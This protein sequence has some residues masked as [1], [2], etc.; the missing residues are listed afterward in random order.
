MKWCRIKHYY[1]MMIVILMISTVPVIITG[2]LSYWQSSQAIQNYSNQEKMQ[3]IYQIQTNVEQVLKNIDHSITYF[4]RTSQL[5]QYIHESISAETFSDYDTI[6]RDLNHLQTLDTGIEDIVLVSLEQGWLINNNG[7]MHIDQSTKESITNHYLSLADNSTWI[8]EEYETIGLPHTVQ[9]RSSHYI[10]LAKKLPLLASEKTGLITVFIPSSA[11]TEIMERRVDAESF[12]ILDEAN[13]I[14]SHSNSNYIGDNFTMPEQIITSIRSQ[15]KEGQFDHIIDDIPYKV[16]YLHSDYNNWTY[17]SLVKVSDLNKRS[18][19]IGWI[20][21][22]ICSI[23]LLLSLIASILSSKKLYRPIRRIHEL[24]SQSN[25]EH[26]QQSLVNQNEFSL[27]ETHINQLLNKNKHLEV[28]MQNQ[29]SQLKQ[30]FIIRLLQGKVTANEIPIKLNAFN[31]PRVWK[32]LTLLSLQIDTLKNHSFDKSNSDLLLFAINN[33][34]E[35]L[36]DSQKRLTPVVINHTQSTILINN[37]DDYQQYMRFINDKANYIQKEV[38]RIFGLSISI[39][40][41]Q[42]FKDLIEAKEA[43]HESIE[44]L[45]YRIKVGAESVIFFDNLNRSGQLFIDYPK[46]IKY[47]LFDAIK[48][49]N[50]TKADH[51][52]EKLF[53]YINREDHHHNYYQIILTRFLY[54]LIELKQVLGVE[55]AQ[56]DNQ[57]FLTEFFEL[58]TLADIK[59]WFTQTFIYPLIEKVE[60]RTK[61]EDKTLSEKIIQII[62]DEFDHDISLD[63]I[64]SKLHYNPNYLSNIFQKETHRSFSEYLLLYR[65]AKAKEWLAETNMSVKEIAA[66]LKYNNSQNFIRSFRRIEGLTPGKYRNELR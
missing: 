37:N 44:A 41:S 7:L 5:Q 46:N 36:I 63:I 47:K 25:E 19:S 15:A 45:K 38:K 42:P 60:A 23:L 62:Q 61:S 8:L 4:V 21:F 55:L 24:V 14:I 3:N 59:D 53:T 2:T 31:Y 39:G 20:T 34:I 54:D 65:I 22:I 17:L 11:L 32:Q 40:I 12:L 28:R 33:I 13:Q 27:I 6:K 43:Y 35:D 50:R 29:V 49:A 18:S 64:A 9:H 52:S 1:K 51:E 10:N 26:Q 58:K 66:K 56:E 30:L 48:L 57:V 16:T